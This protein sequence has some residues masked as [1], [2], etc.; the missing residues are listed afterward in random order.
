MCSDLEK[1]VSTRQN[2][3]EKIKEVCPDYSCTYFPAEGKHMSFVKYKELTGNFFEDKGQCLLEAWRILVK[4]E[5][6]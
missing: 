1:E 5:P 6:R 4:G 3:F 2:L